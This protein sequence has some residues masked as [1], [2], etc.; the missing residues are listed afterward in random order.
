MNRHLTQRSKRLSWLLRHGAFE[1]RVDMDAAGYVP[2]EQVLAHTRLRR[3]EL[4]EIVAQNNKAR[5]QVLGDRIRACQGH[6]P[7]GT[8]V[9]AEALEA[10]WIRWAGGGPIWHGTRVEAL[11]A[12]DA[13]GL[14]P[15]RRTHVHLA[16]A[17]DSTVG[18]RA[19]VA[20]ML[21]VDPGVAAAAGC[22]VFVAPN[23]V[24]LA[25][26]VPRAAIVGARP[27]TRAACAQAEAIHG[28]FGAA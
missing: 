25:R 19:A 11:A 5:L 4:A 7:T 12:I 1:A 3:S 15:G 9:T 20:V 10:T 23:G 8:P 16:E 24:L 6:S 27:M 13:D 18:K 26:R 17:L 14:L 22:P 2:I 21:A 28:R